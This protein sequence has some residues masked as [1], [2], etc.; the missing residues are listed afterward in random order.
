MR[1]RRAPA[2]CRTA[3]AAGEATVELV[4]GLAF[5]LGP[6]VALV[7][8]LP[9]WAEARAAVEAAAAEAAHAV[10]VATDPV[11]AQEDAERLASEI[12]ANHGVEGPVIVE[13][14]IPRDADGRAAREGDVVARVEV[15]LPFA[16]IPGV[17]RVGGFAMAATHA[18]PL[19]PWR[20]RSQ[21]TGLG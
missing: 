7:A 12:V 1:R 5:I 9:Q 2:G 19:D 3:A 4:A 21:R 17:G 15:G 18:E 10:V 14:G 16:W 13:V 6:L 11:D 8:V 20:Q